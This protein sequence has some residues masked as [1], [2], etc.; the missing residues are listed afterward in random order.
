M[1]L[2]AHRAVGA[3][4]RRTTIDNGAKPARNEF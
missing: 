4:R 2:S 1:A 3:S